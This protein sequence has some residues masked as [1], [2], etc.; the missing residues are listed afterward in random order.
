MSPE[1]FYEKIAE[2]LLASTGTEIQVQGQT[3]SSAGRHVG[4]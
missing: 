4:R 3:S 1:I 2:G